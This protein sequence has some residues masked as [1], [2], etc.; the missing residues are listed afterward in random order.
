V[1]EGCSIASSSTNKE[2]KETHTYIGFENTI[3]GVDDTKVPVKERTIQKS[4]Q[5]VGRLIRVSIFVLD[6]GVGKKKEP[7]YAAIAGRIMSNDAL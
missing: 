6:V 2:E 1:W 5:K 7:L 4:L 3:E